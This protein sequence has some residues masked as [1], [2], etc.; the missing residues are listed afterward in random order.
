MIEIETLRLFLVSRPNPSPGADDVPAKPMAQQ[1]TSQW[2]TSAGG[3]TA[4]GAA[5]GGSGLSLVTG[6]KGV[7]AGSSSNSAALPGAGKEATGEARAGVV[8]G[9]GGVG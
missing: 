9:A 7:F 5:A 2:M 6:A 1:R 3:A 4:G 8:V